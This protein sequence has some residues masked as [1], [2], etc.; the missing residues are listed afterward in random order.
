MSRTEQSSRHRARPAQTESAAASVRRLRTRWRG[1]AAALCPALALAVLAAPAWAAKD[2]VELVSR[3][4]GA[5]GAKGN[6]HSFWSTISADGRF[7]AFASLATNLHPDATNNRDHIFVRDL[8]AGTTALASR[9]TGATGAR[10]SHPSFEPSISADGRFV[11]FES[12]SFNLHPD[13]DDGTRD[14]FVRD[15]QTNTTTL[16]SRASGATGE[17][18]DGWNADI[19]ADGRFVAFT[20]A[21]NLHPDD[22]APADVFVRDLQT[23]T[24]TLVSRAAGAGGATG[25]GNSFEPSISADGRFVAFHSSSSNLDPDDDDTTTDVFVRDLQANTTALVSRADGAGGG[26]G[27]GSSLVPSISADGRFVA[28]RSDASNLHPDDGDVG[29]DAFVRD[30]QTNTTTLVSRAAGAGGAKGD[31]DSLLPR[32]SANGRFV[33]FVSA[34]SNLHADDGDTTADVFVRDL[35][36]HTNVLV[37]R[38]G[39]A[40]GAK[41]NAFSNRP[42]ISPDGRFVAFDS[43][44][45]NLHPDDAGDANLDVFRRDVLGPPPAAQPPVAQPP[46]AQP[47]A[48]QS[49]AQ[50]GCPLTGTVIVGTDGDDER[51]GGP[52][53]DVIF[54]ALGD[55]LLRGLAGADC[56]YGQGGADRLHGA[57]GRDRLFGGRGQDRLYGARGR[58]RLRG[59]SGGD[60]LFGGPGRDRI[61]PGAGS[62]RIAAG[63]G[64]DRVLARGTVRDRIDCGR[65]RRDVAIVDALDT[66]RNCEKVR[67]LPPS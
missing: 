8:D 17:K 34:A 59:G 44:A 14:V 43:I 65:G 46:A 58:D 23:N 16:V 56:L 18:G 25:D 11:A 19:S 9:A 36:A 15:L 55:D 27:N 21:S 62:D 7:V 22:G 32:I 13:D 42:A 49:P 31:G 5:T 40:T 39:G 60:R 61:D 47:P 57:R 6:N 3:A 26:K 35:Q 29:P 66:T 28:F 24:T 38:A 63:G 10:G 45:S 41:G 50:P 64:N 37:S 53:S 48:A 67:R 51:A 2:D 33:A 30:L 4:T 1:V 52:L 12:L 54:G 20:S